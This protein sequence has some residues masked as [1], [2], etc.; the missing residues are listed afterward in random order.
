M[1]I[2]TRLLTIKILDQMKDPKLNETVK[3]LGIVDTSHYK[4]RDK[5]C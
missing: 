2:K 3:R 4:R 5:K 1:D